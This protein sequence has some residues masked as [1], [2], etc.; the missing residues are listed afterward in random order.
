M[1]LLFSDTFDV[2]SFF[3]NFVS[4]IQSILKS[5]VCPLWRQDNEE[6]ISSEYEWESADD[7]SA[8]WLLSCY[9]TT[10]GAPALEAL[11]GHRDCWWEAKARVW[12]ART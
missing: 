5:S 10:F 3:L 11:L 9:S 4:V 12:L 2:K 6:A 7:P 8:I 1:E